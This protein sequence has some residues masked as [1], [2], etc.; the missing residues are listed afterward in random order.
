[1]ILL[2][3]YGTHG[4]AAQRDISITLIQVKGLIRLMNPVSAILRSTDPVIR[5]VRA[6]VVVPALSVHARARQIA[7]IEKQNGSRVITTKETSGSKNVSF[8]AS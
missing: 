7:A 6:A 3:T 1:L 2:R 4:I 8:V 5:V